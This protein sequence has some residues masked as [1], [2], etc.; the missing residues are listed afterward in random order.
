MDHGLSFLFIRKDESHP[1]IA[2]QVRWGEG[3]TLAVITHARG[4]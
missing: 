2:E 3:E 1:W 4:S